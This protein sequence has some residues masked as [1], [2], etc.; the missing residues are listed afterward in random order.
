MDKRRLVG[1]LAVVLLLVG[2]LLACF[3][4]G[5]LFNSGVVHETVN[6]PFVSVTHTTP[7]HSSPW[8]MVGY[9]LAGVGLLGLVIAFAM[10]K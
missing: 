4:P 5:G 9:G 2:V 10:K 8:P 6:L 7:G 1:G 3:A